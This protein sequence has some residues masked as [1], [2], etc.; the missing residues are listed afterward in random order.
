M[1]EIKMIVTYCNPN[2]GHY[3]TVYRGANFL[4]LCAEHHSFIPFQN[5]EYVSPRKCNELYD[6]HGAF[7]CLNMLKPSAI[8]PLPLLIYYYPVRVN[9][10]ERRRISVRHCSLSYPVD[11]T[12]CRAETENDL[13]GN[14][15]FST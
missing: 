3:G 13:V 14:E 11:L 10:E 4:P 8:K 12:I 1:P 9:V 6:Q 5:T 2:A 7:K 15:G